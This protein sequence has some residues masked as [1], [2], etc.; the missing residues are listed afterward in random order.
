MSLAG[1]AAHGQ[2]SGLWQAGFGF[3]SDQA[4]GEVFI[5]AGCLSPS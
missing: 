5:L 1:G 3:L 2:A 4:P